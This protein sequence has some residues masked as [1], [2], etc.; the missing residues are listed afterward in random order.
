MGSPMA[1]KSLDQMLADLLTSFPDNNTKFITPLVLRTYFDD[2]IKALRPSYAWLIRDAAVVQAVTVAPAPLV[3]TSAEINFA[4]G[5]YSA[6]PATGRITR[7]DGGVVQFN[8]TADISSPSNSARLITFTIYKNGV[9]TPFKQ[10][11]QLTV[12]GE[13]VS[14]SFGAVQSSAT[15]A[16]YDMYVQSSVNENITFSNM[17]WLAQTVPANNPV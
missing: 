10:S 17:V 8:F 12:S 14:L 15:A 16:N 13:V 5:E 11:Q 3:F 4:Q 6:V 9:P 1:R 2:L 7:L